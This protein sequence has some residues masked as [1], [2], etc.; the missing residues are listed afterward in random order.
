MMRL[1]LTTWHRKTFAVYL[2][3]LMGSGR[4]ATLAQGIV[5]GPFGIY[6]GSRFNVERLDE[7]ISSYTLVHLPS[8]IAKLTLP[9]QGLCR[10][11][12]EEFA[13][14]DLAWESAWPFDITGAKEEL[15]KAKEIYYRWKA[16]RER[17]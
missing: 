6:A 17:R 1:T 5:S 12:A 11:A 10:K 13:A 9:R 4:R 7:S 16:Q 2:E 8:Q 14:C 3:S 15:A